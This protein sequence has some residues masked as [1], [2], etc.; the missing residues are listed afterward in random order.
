MWSIQQ[1]FR[2]ISTTD[3]TSEGDDPFDFAALNASINGTIQRLADDLARVRA[4]GGRLSS[5]TLA[6]LKVQLQKGVKESVVKL[7]DVAQVVPRGGRTMVVMVAEKEHLKAI[8]SS[9]Q[10]ST[11]SL[12]PQPDPQN[13]LH[14]LLPVAAPSQESRQAALAQVSRAGDAAQTAVRNARQT[15][16]KRLR[17]LELERKVRPDDLRRAGKDMEKLV[18]GGTA[19]L[20]RVVDAVKRALSGA[21]S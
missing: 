5:E 8:Q 4:A 17:R 9:I 20:R 3:A 14:L 13:G 18:E 16:Q 1:H 19:E 6:N 21:G 2:P 10:G 11:L 7:G 12:T 15:Q